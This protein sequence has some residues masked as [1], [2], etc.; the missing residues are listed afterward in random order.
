MTLP[1]CN[2]LL[3]A[4]IPTFM[5]CL[6]WAHLKNLL[7][8]KI[9]LKINLKLIFKITN[10]FAISPFLL[11]SLIPKGVLNSVNLSNVQD[12]IFS[13]LNYHV[14]LSSPLP[15]GQLPGL[16]NLKGCRTW[17]NIQSTIPGLCSTL[18]FF[19]TKDP[20]AQSP[21]QTDSVHLDMKAVQVS[22]HN[23]GVLYAN[24]SLS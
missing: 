17:H 4:T 18:M 8:L 21:R 7:I 20:P 1:Y 15:L 9:I 23:S 11:L 14:G 22:N 12:W 24:I 19:H 5:N 3:H 2:L 16:V 6:H 13:I 10:F